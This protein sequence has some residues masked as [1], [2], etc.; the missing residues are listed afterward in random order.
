MQFMA[1][2]RRPK[3][4]SPIDELRDEHW[5]TRIKRWFSCRRNAKRRHLPARERE[6]TNLWPGKDDALLRDM[7]QHD[8]RH[9][10]QGYTPRRSTRH[11]FART[12][13]VGITTPCEDLRQLSS[14]TRL[15]PFTGLP[16]VAVRRSIHPVGD[17]RTPRSAGP[18]CGRR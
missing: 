17:Q 1:A 3:A 13:T 6:S 10:L 2:Q 16:C 14:L 8:A 9:I 15:R 7:P 4:S 18:R 11:D 12:L 5:P